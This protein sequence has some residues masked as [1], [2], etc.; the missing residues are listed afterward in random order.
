MTLELVDKPDGSVC[1]F[2][3]PPAAHTLRVLDWCVSRDMMRDDYR[4]GRLI[5]MVA[6]ATSVQLPLHTPYGYGY[7]F[8]S[9]G[10]YI[11]SLFVDPN[12]RG[13]AAHEFACNGS[14]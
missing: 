13:V 7:S 5:M 3:L 8:R 12:S 11:E 10:I 4:S 9:Q 6:S 14:G 2:G 1:Y